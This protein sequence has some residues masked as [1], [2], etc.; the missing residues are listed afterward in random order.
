MGKRGKMERNSKVCVE[1]QNNEKNR[2]CA[3]M[4]GRRNLE[5]MAIV[6]IILLNK[7]SAIHFL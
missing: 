3:Q 6:E 7:V 4:C 2:R 1:V 5:R